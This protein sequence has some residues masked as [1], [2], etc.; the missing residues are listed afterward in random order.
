MEPNC[1]IDFLYIKDRKNDIDRM[2]SEINVKI[3]RLSSLYID[4]VTKLSTTDDYLISL[5]TLNF[6]ETLLLTER[7]NYNKLY[8]LFL[9]KTYCQYFKL[10][11]KIKIFIDSMPNKQDLNVKLDRDFT[12]YKDLSDHVCYDFIETEAISTA[13]NDIL[14]NTNEYI[15]NQKYDLK[16]DQI[17]V[18]K[19]INISNLLCEKQH[20]ISILEDKILLYNTIQTNYLHFQE[21]FLKRLLLKIKV[22]YSQIN[23]DIEFE[24]I[25]CSRSF[26][27][28]IIDDNLSPDNYENFSDL[29]ENELNSSDNGAGTG[30]KINKVE[31]KRIKTDKKYIS[32]IIAIVPIICVLY[33][34]LDPILIL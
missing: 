12:I 32:F 19:G 4:Y 34:K 1:Q 21:T 15:K 31:K 9:N 17:R 2:M 26:I 10:Y 20:D 3:Q 27:T 18:K 6:Q 29:V 7:N 13:I 28:P 14:I 30:I 11:Y 25:P 33:K 5:D 23:S 22:L 16:D 24:A 8:D